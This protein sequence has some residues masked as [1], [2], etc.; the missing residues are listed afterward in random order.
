MFL[1]CKSG[2]GK[3]I[4]RNAVPE[5]WCC[6]NSFVVNLILSCRFQSSGLVTNVG[7]VLFT[8][9]CLDAGEKDKSHIGDP[10]NVSDE[11]AVSIF[12]VEDYN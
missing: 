7:F 6:V 4:A 1:N 10:T 12:K 8:D 2:V 3:L 11:H 5:N 9:E